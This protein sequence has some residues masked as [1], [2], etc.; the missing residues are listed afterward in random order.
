MGVSLAGGERGGTVLVGVSDRA[1]QSSTLF[2][3]QGAGLG[4]SPHLRAAPAHRLESEENRGRGRPAALTVH[5]VLRRGGCSR[6][7]PTARPPIVR[8]EWPC[9]GQLLHIDTKR[10]GKFT[11]AGHAF[12]GDRARR[13]RHAG[14]EYVHSIVDDCS[15][16]AYSEIH[17]DE[18]ATTV[19]AFTHRA[20]D[21]FLENGIVAERL[22]SDNAFAYVRNKSL[23]ALLHARAI[24]HLRIRP[25]TPRTNGKVERYQQTLQREW[26]YAMEY[27]SSDARRASLPH[28]VDHYNERRTHSALNNRPPRSRVR[29]VTGHNS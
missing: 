3:A 9:P 26:A 24:D 1:F 29:D 19:T 11:E 7:E 16:L 25:Y 12:T 2:A 17:D 4:G 5:Q 15:R 23:K 21:W 22:M 27:A 18:L 8:Y 14:W 20:L 6:R 10:L 28:W 13:S